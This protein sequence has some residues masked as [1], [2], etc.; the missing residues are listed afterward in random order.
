MLGLWGLLWWRLLKAPGLLFA[1]FGVCLALGNPLAPPA[2]HQ[3]ALEKACDQANR[4][5]ETPKT[6]CISHCAPVSWQYSHTGAR[7]VPPL[8]TVTPFI[9][10]NPAGPRAGRTPM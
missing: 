6:V 1:G 10:Q 9:G 3:G 8:R 7:F 2:F 5:Q 4:L